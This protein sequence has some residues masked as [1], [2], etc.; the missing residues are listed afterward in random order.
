M[1]LNSPSPSQMAVP[2]NPSAC[3]TLNVWQTLVDCKVVEP[4]RSRDDLF[5][6]RRGSAQLV[7]RCNGELN[8]LTIYSVLVS[9]A[10]PSTAL[11]RYLL[12]FNLLQRRETLGLATKDGRLMIVLKYTMEMEYLT[13]PMLQRQILALQEAADQVDTDLAERFGGNLHFEDWNRLNQEQVNGLLEDL[14]N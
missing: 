9:G 3:N 11:F 4:K 6:W 2:S 5:L 13:G 12:S 8:N 10:Q 14:F 1:T 7:L